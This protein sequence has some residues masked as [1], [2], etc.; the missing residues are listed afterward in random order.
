MELATR[1]LLKTFATTFLPLNDG[2]A[3]GMVQHLTLF[4]LTRS[5]KKEANK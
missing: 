4:Y 3:A 5:L 1:F 2:K